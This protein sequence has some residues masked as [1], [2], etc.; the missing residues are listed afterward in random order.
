MALY[1]CFKKVP[2]A[3]PIPNGSL[4]GCMLSEAISLAI[5]DVRIGSPKHRAEQ[6]DHKYDLRSIRWFLLNEKP[7]F[8]HCKSILIQALGFHV[9][10]E[11]DVIDYEGVSAM[12][13][14]LAPTSSY[15]FH[16]IKFF[17]RFVKYIDHKI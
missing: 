11:V 15:S 12:P 5:W 3:L 14:V 10:G 4:W 13:P 7:F 6:Y 1:E 8:F 2:N 9:L 17:H 16:E